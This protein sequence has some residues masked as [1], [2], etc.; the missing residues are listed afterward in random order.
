MRKNSWKRYIALLV[1]LALC[2]ALAACGG[3]SKTGGTGAAT[4]D[5]VQDEASL[6]EGG[7]ALELPQDGRKRIMNAQ[8]SMEALDFDATLD[9]LCQAAEQ[10]GGYVSSTYVEG[11]AEEG[12]RRAEYEFRI[13]AEEYAAF[14]TATNDAGNVTQKSESVQD[15]TAQYV[16]VEARL[17]SLEAQHESLTRMLEQAQ[18]VETLLA[19]QRELADVQYEIES[20]TAQKRTYD[21]QVAYST[22]Q[23]SVYEVR[24]VTESP[25]SF[26]SRLGAAFRSGWYGL[27]QGLQ[28]I[29]VAFAA[30][31]PA[32][33]VLACVALAI[34]ALVRALMR[35]R[36]KRQRGPGRAPYGAGVPGPAVPQPM[37]MP[38]EKADEQN[39]NGI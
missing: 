19:I 4:G 15:I 35:R 5:A 32:L 24:R 11:R 23:V 9:A 16:D 3:A 12:G 20:Y 37:E 33:L 18:D 2:A 6:A 14:L 7:T 8:L 13:P 36:P 25:Q 31:L 17:A 10:A 26:A 1:V 27:G 38:A 39:P 22:V 28:G 21:D 34:W 29:A 30:M